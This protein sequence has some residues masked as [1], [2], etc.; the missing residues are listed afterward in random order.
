M[1]YGKRPPRRPGLLVLA[2]CASLVS[3]S[4]GAVDP[5]TNL[6]ESPRSPDARDLPEMTKLRRD[7]EN[8][9]PIA[10]SPL[11]DEL[12]AVWCT[13]EQGT[14]RARDAQHPQLSMPR[15][16]A[17]RRR[18]C[19][20]HDLSFLAFSVLNARISVACLH[21]EK[22]IPYPDDQAADI[23]TVRRNLDAVQNARGQ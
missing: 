4:E 11:T 18:L 22:R 12:V 16:Q 17:L 21:I 13:I 9:A 6:Q 1:D 10:T 20:D 14:R 7:A 3:C 8:A 23:E 19:A 5:E 2:L 15:E